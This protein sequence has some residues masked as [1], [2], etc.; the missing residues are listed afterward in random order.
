[1]N[2]TK[3]ASVLS[4]AA[5]LLSGEPLFKPPVGAHPGRPTGDLARLNLI[6][7]LSVPLRGVD[8][9]VMPQ[10]NEGMRAFAQKNEH[11][12]GVG[13]GG[14]DASDTFT[15]L[16][17]ALGDATDQITKLY[18]KVSSEGASQ[19]EKKADDHRM[20]CEL[21]RLINMIE[22]IDVIVS[23]HRCSGFY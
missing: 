20:R 7:E 18:P 17:G 12:S 22:Q 5:L 15:R 19:D 8:Q 3:V 13:I 6:D 23:E 11:L 21:T 14:Q 1:M 9:R 10:I 2:I 4:H 16:L